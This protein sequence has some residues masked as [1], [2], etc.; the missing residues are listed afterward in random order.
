MIALA[1]AEVDVVE[2]CHV[3]DDWCARHEPH[4]ERTWLTYLLSRFGEWCRA[5]DVWETG[6]A[7]QRAVLRQRAHE[8]VQGAKRLGLFIE[9]DPRLGYRVTGHDDLPKYVHLHE[10]AEDRDDG[11]TPGQLTLAEC[12]GV[13]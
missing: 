10:R 3:A 5:S 6:D 8:V 2:P 7:Y 11:Q 12:A 9:A 4:F 13:E 1:G